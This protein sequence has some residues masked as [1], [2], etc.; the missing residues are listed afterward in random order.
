MCPLP[1]ALDET[2]VG[3]DVAM[4]WMPHSVTT[5]LSFHCTIIY[6]QCTAIVDF[7]KH[8]NYIKLPL[9]IVSLNI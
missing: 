2:L 1:A 5:T 8:L 9:G 4:K 3:I 6:L 7:N